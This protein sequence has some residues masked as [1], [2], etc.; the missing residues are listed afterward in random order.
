LLLAGAAQQFQAVHVRHH[1][2]GE[3]HI[4]SR[5]IQQFQ[6]LMPTRCG[7]GVI[8]LLLESHRQ[9]AADILLVIHD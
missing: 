1:H 2:I 8:A 9:D 7:D 4:A 6:G 5:L 3:H